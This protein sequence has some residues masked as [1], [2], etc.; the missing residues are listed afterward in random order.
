M[1]LDEVLQEEVIYNEDSMVDMFVE[2]FLFALEMQENGQK[3][4]SMEELSETLSEAANEAISELSNKI[5]MKAAGKAADK[6]LEYN[7]KM[8]PD[9]SSIVNAYN[10]KKALEK[11]RQAGRLMGKGTE[12]ILRRMNEFDKKKK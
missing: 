2:G 11:S 3:A 7:K 8:S 1:I 12:R 5:V 6:A 9:K 4:S 10:F